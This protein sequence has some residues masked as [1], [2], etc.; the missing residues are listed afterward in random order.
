[1]ILFQKKYKPLILKGIKEWTIRKGE[2]KRMKIGSIH[3]CKTSIFTGEFFARI[4]IK[5]L[6]VKRF[7]EL[8][9][10]DA[11]DDLFHSVKEMKEELQRL[12]GEITANTLMT[13]INF[14]LVK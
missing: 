10:K 7:D 13:K 9:E 14:E 6:I 8:D 5:Q 4:R 12:N 1:M 11:K 3:Q 2:R